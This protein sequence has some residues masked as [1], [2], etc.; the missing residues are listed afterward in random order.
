MTTPLKSSAE[1]LQE[2]QVPAISRGSSPGI[3]VQV[4]G[5][6][7]LLTNHAAREDETEKF[8]R[9]ELSHLMLPAAPATGTPVSILTRP[10]LMH[11]LITCLRACAQRSTPS[12]STHRRLTA[13][14]RT[15]MKVF[16]FGWLRG[17][18]GLGDWSKADFEDL[19]CELSRGG[20]TR[21]LG[22]GQRAIEYCNRQPL[23]EIAA[24]IK[25]SHAHSGGYSIRDSFAI[26]IGTNCAHQELVVAKEVLVEHLRLPKRSI[27]A[28][29]V[30]RT[31]HRSDIA[32]MS[33]THIRQE[34][35]SM[36]L[37]GECLS[38]EEGLSF[39]PFPNTVQAS[40]AYGRTGNRTGNLEPQV[41]ASLLKES[42]WWIADVSGSVI[43]LVKELQLR[44][45]A[46]S[47]ADTELSARQLSRIIQRSP[48]TR[49]IEAL[50]D[51]QVETTGLR[52]AKESW[53]ISRVIYTMYAA[54][55]V[56]IAFLNAR[57]R[58]EIEHRKIGLHRHALK[59]V[60]K[61][62][63]LYE[64]EFYLEKTFKDYVTFYV[65]NATRA[66]IEVLEVL[67]DVARAIDRLRANPALSPADP[68]EDK[69]FHLPRPLGSSRRGHQWF[70]FNASSDGF[71]RDLI[72]RALG[73]ESELHVHPHMFRRAYALIYHYRFELGD[74]FGLGQQLGHN[75]L[76]TTLIYVT[77]AP[78]GPLSESTAAAY[79]RRP[80]T[81][82]HATRLEIG[83]LESE[84]KSVG[85]ERVRI[86]AKE[87]VQGTFTDFGGFARVVRRFH[88]LM[89]RRIDYSE[90][91][92]ERQ[93]QVLSEPFVNQGHMFRPMRHANCV[94]SSVRRSK[95]AG[96]YNSRL[97]R[98]A[99]ESA[100]AATCAG[101]AFSH[102]TSSH[103]KLWEADARELDEDAKRQGEN[104]L[105]GRG[106]I[107]Q[108]ANIRR[109][110]EL[111]SLRMGTP[112]GDQK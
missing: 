90:L 52:H 57:R 20:W 62:L 69:L 79:A 78:G 102:F 96:C 39:I 103:I 88:Q 14:L 80:A 58:D 2:G 66:A 71:A 104:S 25:A 16:E 37:L 85:V 68:R 89:S 17:L 41:V 55:F 82:A 111:V 77:D 31:K 1:S 63:G 59:P 3:S 33:Q 76:E 92:S 98:N 36:N 40:Q 53:S 38:A 74:L 108:A 42:L 60:D 48:S 47:E 110:I 100:S 45:E 43:D 75:D 106:S 24:Q 54:C 91:D 72:E 23:I 95:S 83:E 8:V 94:A 46:A 49:A 34:M 15:L 67:S 93:A 27:K 99:P 13:T 107:A 65:G 18:Y 109:V 21:A 12:K 87:V 11:A 7:I 44:L 29:R 28:K 50:L 101:C 22:I 4:D 70:S 26:A 6:Q 97:Q 19:A 5:G 81:P 61:S 30:K 64:C 35:S 51:V 105:S 112:H 9:H 84:I 32:G 86:L 10:D 56:V 73:Q